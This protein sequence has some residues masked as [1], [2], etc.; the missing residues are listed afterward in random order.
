MRK[1][2]EE[3]SLNR[4]Y[5]HYKNYDTGIITAFRSAKLCGLGEK[6][7]KREN[8]DRNK[9]L[10]RKLLADKFSVTKIR[11]VFVENYGSENERHVKENSFFVSD[12]KNSKKLLDS[13]MKYGEQYEQDAIIFGYASDNYYLISTNNCPDGYPGKGQIGVKEILGTPKMGK[14]S[15]FYSMVKNKPFT[16]EE[17]FDY[18]E[19]E[20]DVFSNKDPKVFVVLNY[21][22]GKISFFEK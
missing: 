3:T 21:K 11:G 19:D 8:K 13:L 17:N 2:L 14:T 9:E 16:I 22:S 15:Q 20:N 7:N 4:I 6:Y 5:W 12:I 18:D 1:R 10:L